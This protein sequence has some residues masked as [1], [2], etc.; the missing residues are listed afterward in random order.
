[1]PDLFFSIL[2]EMFLFGKAVGL[3]FIGVSRFYD[4]ITPHTISYPPPCLTVWDFNEFLKTNVFSVWI[5]AFSESWSVADFFQNPNI[6]V[7]RPLMN[8]VNWLSSFKKK[9]KF[10][11]SCVTVVQMKATL[12]A[13]ARLMHFPI[14]PKLAQH[15]EKLASVLWFSC[16]WFTTFKLSSKANSNIW[17]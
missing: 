13:A 11:A 2:L 3:T 1:M 14:C 8:Q 4:Y 6:A 12:K 16:K 10:C 9:K 15:R 7:V 5:T 17:R